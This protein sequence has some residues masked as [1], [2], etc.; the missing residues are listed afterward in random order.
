MAA[1]ISSS[2][3]RSKRGGSGASRSGLT[4]SNVTVFDGSPARLRPSPMRQSLGLDQRD[5]RPVAFDGEHRDV[6]R[7]PA[8]RARRSRGRSSVPSAL[9]VDAVER[10]GRGNCHRAGRRFD[11]RLAP[12]ASR[13]RASRRAAPAARS[14]RPRSGSQSRRQGWRRRRRDFPAPRRAAARPLR[15]RATAAPANASSLARLRVWGS[16]RS[17]K[18]RAA[19]S[20][21]IWSLSPATVAALYQ[22]PRSETAMVGPS[23]IVGKHGRHAGV[24]AA[25]FSPVDRAYHTV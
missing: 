5:G 9:S 13:R 7:P 2:A 22:F 23:G 20:A 10:P 6:L 1:P 24:A 15:A 12:A 14:A 8:R 19:V 16:A 25:P 11:A 4:R 21:T 18:I 17:A 3:P